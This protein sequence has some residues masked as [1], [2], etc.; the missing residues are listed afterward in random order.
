MPTP[1]T[2]SLLQTFFFG[3]D[4]TFQ[5]ALS[6]QKTIWQQIAM[7]KTSTKEEEVYGWLDVIPQLRKWLGPRVVNQLSARAQRLVNELFEDTVGVKRTKLEDDTAGIY[8][9]WARQLGAQSALW[10]EQR[11]IAAIKAGGTTTV[12]DNQFFFD[13]DHP[14]NMDNANSAVQSNDFDYSVNGWD[15]TAATKGFTP[16]NV[17]DARAKMRSLKMANGDSLDVDPDTVLVPTVYEYKA[18]TILNAAIIAQPVGT[19]AAAAV[20]NQLKGLMKP[21][22]ASRLDDPSYIYLLDCR[23]PI[24]PF[25]F[26]QRVAPEMTMRFNPEDPHVF[27]ADEFLAGVRARGEAGYGPWWLA[28]RMKVA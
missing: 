28:A 21:V 6:S 5:Q 8:S 4:L 16:E 22:V 23:M 27:D 11:V 14:V 18:A 15:G 7:L 19:N 17:A 3:L 10:P 25:L 13:T 12:Y 20:D 24:K 2:P 1:L 26:Q 9:D